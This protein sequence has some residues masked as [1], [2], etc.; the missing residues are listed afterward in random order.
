MAARNE[1][2]LKTRNHLIIFENNKSLKIMQAN[3][4]LISWRQRLFTGVQQYI[5]E[6]QRVPLKQE[7][8]ELA[9]QRAIHLSCSPGPFFSVVMDHKSMQH[10]SVGG[11][12]E[13]I[14]GISAEKWHNKPMGEFIMEC[15]HPDDVMPFFNFAKLVVDYAET[16]TIPERFKL[17]WNFYYRV[18][19]KTGKIKYI[20]HQGQPLM[21]DEKGILLASLE[22][23]ADIS[24]IRNDNE[25]MLTI[26][27]FNDE[28]N[29][30]FFTYK[31]SDI[32]PKLTQNHSVLSKR[33]QQIVRLLSE[34]YTSKQVAY[35]INISAVTVNNHRQ[36]MLRKTNTSS[37]AELVKY[38]FREGII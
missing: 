13:Q 16:L 27:N 35:E 4:A 2:N 14:L 33:E 12:V 30:Q 28:K 10:A 17:K 19:D 23:F 22:F 18:K 37:T 38:V 9:L 6:D 29:Q 24:H 34:G 1:K 15:I 25:P 26:L 20:F 8:F 21:A 31:T 3:E 11:A 5:P 7:E 32:A 36:N